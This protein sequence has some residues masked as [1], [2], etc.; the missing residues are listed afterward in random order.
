MGWDGVGEHKDPTHSLQ[1]LVSQCNPIP[2]A[3]NE[4]LISRL[5]VRFLPRSPTNP[6][7]LL[8]LQ[9]P[10]WSVAEGPDPHC[11]QNCAHP[12]TFRRRVRWRLPEGGNS[13]G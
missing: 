4:L 12:P 9:L 8:Q 3:L 11:A 1:L 13:A 7:C 10:R 6:H 2:N 5:K